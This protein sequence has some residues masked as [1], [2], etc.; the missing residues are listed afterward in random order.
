MSLTANQAYNLNL[1]PGRVPVI[2]HTSQYDHGWWVVFTLYNGNEL[3]VIPEGVSGTIR[4][5]RPDGTAYAQEVTVNNGASTVGVSVGTQLNIAAGM[6]AC[7]LVLAD[8][9]GNRIGTANFC[10]KVESAPIDEDAE[11][12]QED[13][14]YAE[15]VLTQLQSV[16]AYNV[17]LTAAESDIDNLQTGLASEASTRQSVDAGIYNALNSEVE[18]RDL[19][20]RG[21]QAQINAFTSM[22]EG[23]TTGDAEL[24]NARVG[25]DAMTYAS[26]GDAIRNN[27]ESLLERIENLE[28]SDWDMTQLTVPSST[29]GYVLKSDG[30][31][32]AKSGYKVT[33]SID[34]S[35]YDYV[36][37]PRLCVTEADP[38]YGML[39]YDA[40]SNAAGRMALGG[41]AVEGVIDT[42]EAVGTNLTMRFTYPS[43]VTPYCY[44]YTKESTDLWEAVT[45][46]ESKLN[47][48]VLMLEAFHIIL[49]GTFIRGTVSANGNPGQGQY[50]IRTDAVQIFSESVT[51]TID[52]GYR[53]AVYYYTSNAPSSSTFDH[54]DAWETGTYTFDVN[55][56]FIPVIALVNEDTSVPADLAWRFRVYSDNNPIEKYM[57]ADGT[58]WEA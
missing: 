17:R 32:E 40:E 52:A 16:S 45:D 25:N 14:A 3:F 42:I 22:S 15:E 10:I 34:V 23:S 5:L 2:V 47:E 31:L 9:D 43:G 39:M 46:L 7:E 50:R 30:T 20:D 8:T 6:V 24:I 21:L 29:S 1:R 55:S 26:A 4:A 37:Y 33:G 41:V 48:S 53:L 44:G 11:I 35:A 38:D 19:A 54:Y 51:V 36:R 57:V 58:A 28:G 13:L 56:Y 18:A 27:D 12:T 49:P